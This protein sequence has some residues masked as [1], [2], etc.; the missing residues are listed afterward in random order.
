MSLLTKGP[1]SSTDVHR[2]SCFFVK[3]VWEKITD[4]LHSFLSDVGLTILLPLGYI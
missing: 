1:L 3:L 2:F 4:W